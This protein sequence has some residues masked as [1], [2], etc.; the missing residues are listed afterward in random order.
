LLPY[1]STFAKQQAIEPSTWLLMVRVNMLINRPSKSIPQPSGLTALNKEKIFSRRPRKKGTA[2]I[3][4]IAK[5]PFKMGLST[6]NRKYFKVKYWSAVSTD[7]HIT[8]ASMPR[9]MD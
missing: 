3:P 9:N 4:F 5:Y 8:R 1:L 2:F 6:P 7:A